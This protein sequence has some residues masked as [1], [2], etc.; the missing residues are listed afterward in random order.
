MRDPPHIYLL[1]RSPTLQIPSLQ[2]NLTSSNQLQNKLLTA[3]C[4]HGTITLQIKHKEYLRHLHES[5]HLAQMYTFQVK[6]Q[7]LET[8]E[9]YNTTLTPHIK[10][11]TLIC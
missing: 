11:H 1:P 4:Y 5:Q 8:S 10:S 3:S 9:R 2:E 6:S 7:Y